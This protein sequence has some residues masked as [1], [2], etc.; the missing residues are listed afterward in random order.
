MTRFPCC[1]VRSR[2][3][4]I[5]NSNLWA[6]EREIKNYKTE[7]RFEIGDNIF[8]SLSYDLLLFDRYLIKHLPSLACCLRPVKGCHEVARFMKCLL[9]SVRLYRARW[10]RNCIGFQKIGPL[11]EEFYDDFRAIWIRLF[12]LATV[13]WHF[14]PFT[15]RHSCCKAKVLNKIIGTFQS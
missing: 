10:L 4:C 8:L 2:D 9:P 6:A 13:I 3:P 14:R 15:H 1:R 5:P 11:K 12:V 7:T